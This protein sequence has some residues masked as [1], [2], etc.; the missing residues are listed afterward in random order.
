MDER[1]DF[2]YKYSTTS[3]SDLE[4]K[5]LTSAKQY[6]ADLNGQDFISHNRN[7]TFTFCTLRQNFDALS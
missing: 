2:L 3:A 7:A 6:P 5:G 1:F 4:E